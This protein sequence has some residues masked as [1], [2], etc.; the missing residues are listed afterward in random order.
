M[1]KGRR[2]PAAA[3]LLALAPACRAELKFAPVVDV[4]ETYTDNVNLA[5]S[6]QARSQFL[7]EVAPG[8]GLDDDTSHLQLHAAFRQH[9]FY[10]PNSDIPGTQRSQSQGSLDAKSM[11][12][13]DLLYLDATGSVSQQAVSAFG[14]PVLD[15]GYTTNNRTKVKTYMVSPSLRHDFGQFASGELRA[16]RDSVD[17][18]STGFGNTKGNSVSASLGSGASFRTLGWGLQFYRQVLHDNQASQTPSSSTQSSSATVRYALGPTLTLTGN[19]GYDKN[20][21]PADGGTTAGKF[22]LGGF[23]WGP[24]SRSSLAASVGRRYFGKTATMKAS[25][26]SRGTVWSMSYDDSIS[27]TRSNFLLP[28]SISTSAMLDRLFAATI[29]DPVVRAQI[30]QAYI[31]ATGLPPSLADSVNYLSNRYFRQKQLQAAVAYQST[32]STAMFSLFDTRREAVSQF[33]S[34]SELLGTSL[35]GLNDNT[36][37]IGGTL[38]WNVQMTSRSAVNASYTNTRI[39]STSTG[40]VTHNSAVRLMLNRQIKAK[41]SGTLELRHAMGSVGP[42]GSDY[43]ENAVAASLNM[44]L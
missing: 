14:A 1:V 36:H 4:R 25:H 33:Q 43:K 2:A 28:A 32:H 13:Q 11:L 6:A 22:W 7:T 39:E 38:M 8:F 18:G 30:V 31:A 16:T 10:T 19:S 15:N 41:L 44:Q 34:D 27:T 5:P 37:Q 17:A 12:V 9:L 24:S 35:S 21:Y 3:L 42:I 29:P 26:R 23:E 40:V 20:N